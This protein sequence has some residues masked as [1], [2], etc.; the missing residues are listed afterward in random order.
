MKMKFI[1][2][3]SLIKFSCVALTLLPS[4]GRIYAKPF[5]NTFNSWPSTFSLLSVKTDSPLEIES[6]EHFDT[7]HTSEVL[8]A[9][10]ADSDSGAD[11]TGLLLSPYSMGVIQD[12]SGSLELGSPLNGMLLAQVEAVPAPESSTLFLLGLGLLGLAQV[13]IRRLAKRSR[14]RI[15]RT[16]DV[17]VDLRVSETPLTAQNARTTQEHPFNA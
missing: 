8:L 17:G 11:V 4:S 14:D 7:L 5:G 12:E 16:E 2:S 1:G 13:P 6:L 10:N 15:E 3:N 9:R